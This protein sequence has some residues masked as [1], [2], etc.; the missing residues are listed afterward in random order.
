MPKLETEK[1][2]TQKQADKAARN[3]ALNI[4][5]SWDCPNC[6]HP[7]GG[8]HKTCEGCGLVHDLGQNICPMCREIIKKGALKC[9][10]C[11]EVF[12]EPVGAA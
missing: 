12:S 5:V 7:D 1:E 10:H 6:G 8:A 11:G 3:P 4:R 9:K 2:A